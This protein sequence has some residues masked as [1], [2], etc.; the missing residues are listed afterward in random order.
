MKLV[1]RTSLSQQE[2]DPSEEGTDAKDHLL[3]LEKVWRV[4]T[5]CSA[6]ILYHTMRAPTH[7]V[8]LK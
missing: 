2:K 5:R 6:D 1:H 7:T 8:S 3:Q 4:V